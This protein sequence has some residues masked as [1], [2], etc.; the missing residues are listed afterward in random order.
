MT[1]DIEQCRLSQFNSYLYSRVSL[2]VA[3]HFNYSRLL[4]KDCR[5]FL[6]NLAKSPSPWLRESGKDCSFDCLN[7][8]SKRKSSVCKQN[9]FS[10][11]V[12]VLLT[13]NPLKYSLIGEE[14]N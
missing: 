2:K 11:L 3:D 4:M 10:L 8:E 13:Q 14:A 6:L 1:L 7:I 12:K 9:G 5:I